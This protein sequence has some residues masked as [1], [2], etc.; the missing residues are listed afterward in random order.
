M[1]TLT[2]NSMTDVNMNDLMLLMIATN[3][4][5][6]A[7]VIVALSIDVAFVFTILFGI[8]VVVV[9]ISSFAL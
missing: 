3:V 9:V 8:E 5:V 6:S 7:E 4:A 1:L 2:N